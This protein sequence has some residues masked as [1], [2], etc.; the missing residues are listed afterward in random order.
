[1]S[2]ALWYHKVLGRLAFFN[3]ILH[4]I[5]AHADAVENAFFNFIVYDQMNTSG[6]C[7][8]FL[9]GGVTIT[10]LPQVRH[11]CFEVFY[12]V[13]VTFVFLMT[14]CAFYHSGVY[15]LCRVGTVLVCPFLNLSLT[16]SGECYTQ[17]Y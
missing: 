6:S 2:I 13:H 14:A 17:V 1:M 7:L 10:S 8:F 9:I 12:Y 15:T 4:T 16:T 3:G 11:M 5:V